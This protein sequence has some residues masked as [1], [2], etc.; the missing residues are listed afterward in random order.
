M[1]LLADRPSFFPHTTLLGSS[2]GPVVDTR[3]DMPVGGRVYIDEIEANEIARHFG[4]LNP[5]AA[6]RLQARVGE[7]ERELAAAKT[8][9]R[10]AG[11]LV[12][13]VIG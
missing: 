8:K 4:F 13:D 2:G 5:A 1:F 3:I 7:L 12:A 9:L 10:R 6:A 11:E